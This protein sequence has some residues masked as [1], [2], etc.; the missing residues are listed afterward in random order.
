M[1]VLDSV[2]YYTLDSKFS[3]DEICFR[4]SYLLIFCNCMK[5][6]KFHYT[7]LAV[8]DSVSYSILASRFSAC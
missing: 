3:T 1:T 8:L 2:L 6:I 7:V 5:I 4:N